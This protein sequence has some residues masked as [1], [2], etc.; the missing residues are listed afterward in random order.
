[1]KRL[2]VVMMVVAGM[3]AVAATPTVSNVTA[4][5]R[6]PWDG[7]V[8]ITFTVA[9]NVTTGFPSWNMPRLLISL[10]NR[11]SGTSYVAAEDALS[12]DTGTEEGEHNVVW[13]LNAQVGE[14]ESSNVVF[15]VAYVAVPLYCVIDLS[16]GANATSYPV[17]YMNEPAGGGF[18]TDEYK[19]VKLVLR[20]IEPGLFKMCGSYDVTLTKRFY[21]GIFEVTQKQ[22][23]LVMGS[24]PSLYKGDMR[25]VEYVTWNTIR[26]NSYNSQGSWMPDSNSFLGKIRARTGLDFDLP[27]EAQWEYACRAGTTSSYNNGG[28]TE[29]DLK[30]LGRYHG[31]QADGKGGLSQHTVV[32]SYQSNAW[33]LYDMHGNVMEWCRD[34]YGNLSSGVT[35]PS[36]PSTGSLRMRRGGLS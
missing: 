2:L 36:G 3:T 16:A 5:Q 21:C 7:L 15:T 27:T 12:G 24:N 29:N 6:F 1:M 17:T 22:Y 9:G 34:W 30:L 4:K 14:F 23:E 11:V 25:P 31:N 32:G 28:S 18:N 26:G 20:L 13:N 8:D 19:T 35:D 10:T 33:G